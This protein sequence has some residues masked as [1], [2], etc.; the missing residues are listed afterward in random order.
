[1]GASGKRERIIGMRPEFAIIS[2][3]TVNFLLLSFAN[4]MLRR[5]FSNMKRKEKRRNLYSEELS[6][7]CCSPMLLG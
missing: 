3:P 4:K 1:M 6:N 7:V 5:I 2:F